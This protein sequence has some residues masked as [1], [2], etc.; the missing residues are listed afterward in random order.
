[1]VPAPGGQSCI[2]PRI[3]APAH[4][5]TPARVIAICW[6]LP[7]TSHCR[8]THWPGWICGGATENRLISGAPTGGGATLIVIP[9]V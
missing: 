3:G 7:C 5:V 1:M 8:F 4:K 9:C 2:V 6:M